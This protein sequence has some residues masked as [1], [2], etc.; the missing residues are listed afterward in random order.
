M[1]HPHLPLFTHT[2]QHQLLPNPYILTPMGYHTMHQ[3]IISLFIILS[4]DME[5]QNPILALDMVCQNLF[6]TPPLD[7]VFQNLIQ[8][9]DMVCQSLW[10][11]TW[12][13]FTTQLQ[14]MECQNP[15]ILPQT[16]DM[17]CQN[18]ILLQDMEYQSQFIIPP[19]DMECQN[20]WFITQPQDMEFLSQSFTIQ[21]L[22]MVFLSLFIIQNQ[23]MEFQWP[24]TQPLDMVHQSITM[25]QVSAT[26]NV[27]STIISVI[28]HCIIANFQYCH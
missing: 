5:C 19:Q 14:D 6:I 18:P 13:P 2:I 11:I 10:F 22:D 16:Q 27:G 1:A 15:I 9:L 24:H 25:N 28:N 23:D 20:Q 7:M 12:S 21:L 26:N 3:F 17:V 4:Q 8:A